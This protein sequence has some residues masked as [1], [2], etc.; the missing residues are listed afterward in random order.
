MEVKN[1]AS[2]GYF[3]VEKSFFFGSVEIALFLGL[4]EGECNDLFGE[5]RTIGAAA[6][7]FGE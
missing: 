7:L 3:F 6:S 2:E 4:L 5:G 1:Q